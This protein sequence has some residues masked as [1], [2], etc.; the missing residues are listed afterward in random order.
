MTRYIIYHRSKVGEELDRY[1]EDELNLV[2]N[3]LEGLGKAYYVYDMKTNQ[4]YTLKQLKKREGIRDSVDDVFDISTTEMGGYWESLLKGEDLD[5]LHN[6]KNVKGKIV[7]MTPNQYYRESAKVLNK[8]HNNSKNNFQ[9]LVRTRSIDKNYMKK[10]EEVITK[11]HEKF[12]IPVLD[13]SDN[14]GQEGLHRMMVA[15]NLYGWNTKFPVLLVEN[16]YDEKPEEILRDIINKTKRNEFNNYNEI[17]R[18]LDKLLVNSIFHENFDTNFSDDETKVVII[19]TYRDKDYKAYEDVD[20]F[21]IKPSKY[22]QTKE[23]E[24]EDKLLKQ[25]DL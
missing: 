9:S 20:E 16:Y 12:P 21:K 15:G 23:N 24:E 17:L 18:F 5:Y 13:I 19:A 4:D 6:K 22:N 14:C 2:I 3:E 1:D 7:Y 8:M 11:K 10:L 25:L